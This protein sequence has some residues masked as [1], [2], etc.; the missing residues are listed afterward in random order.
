VTHEEKWAGAIFND[1]VLFAKA[2]VELYLDRDI[3]KKASDKSLTVLEE[4]FDKKLHNTTFIT[5][6]EDRLSNLKN[7]RSNNLMGSIL[8]YHTNRSTKFMSMWIESKNK[9]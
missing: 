6:V 8:N 2:A 5:Y 4:R 3:W 9:Q 7:T 1:N